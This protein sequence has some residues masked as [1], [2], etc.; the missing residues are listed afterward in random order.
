VIKVHDV[1]YT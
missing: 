1:G